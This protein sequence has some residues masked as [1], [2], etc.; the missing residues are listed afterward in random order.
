MKYVLLRV[1]KKTLNKRVN[2][3]V[4][5]NFE[6]ALAMQILPIPAVDKK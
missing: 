1:I 3:R 5:V 4:L 6:L 2:H